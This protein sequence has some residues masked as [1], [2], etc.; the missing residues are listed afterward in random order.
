M[1]FGKH[2]YGRLLSPLAVL[3]WVAVTGGFAGAAQADTPT[4]PA[5]TQAGD[6][7]Q[8]APPEAPA[9]GAASAATNHSP[10]TG[11][12]A[13]PQPLSNADQNTG[14]ANGQCPGGPYCS[15]RDGSAS[16]N[17]NGGGQAV[18]E[19]CAGCVGKADNKNPQ[20]QMPN[21]SDHNAGYECDTNHGIARGNPAH[22]ACP[23]TPQPQCVPTATV[24]CVPCVRSATVTCGS[25]SPECVPTATVPCVPSSPQCVPTPTVPCVPSLTNVS[26]PVAGASV[27]AAARPP[28]T[29]TPVAAGLPNTGAPTGLVG[30]AALA[31]LAVLAGAALVALTRST[32]LDS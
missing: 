32:R 4:D 7:A 24:P 3:V 2:K 11:A 16:A 8:A 6:H 29:V 20:G 17:G 19:P 31:M 10:G 14:G 15:T 26:A 25:S 23:T 18:G 13:D 28:A 27:H 30:E 5:A 22:T 21:A 1:S 12:L 9:P